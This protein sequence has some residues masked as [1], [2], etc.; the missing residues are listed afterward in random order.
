MSLRNTTLSI[1][2]PR[3]L[4]VK[5]ASLYTGLSESTLNNARWRGNGPP[6]IKLGRSVRYRAKDLL[7][8]IDTREVSQ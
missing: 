5:Q 8:Y 7:S 1:E 4:S 2:L 6:Y 3:L